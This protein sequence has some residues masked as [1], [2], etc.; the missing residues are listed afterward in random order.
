MTTTLTILGII[1]LVA[2][3]I[4]FALMAK[5]KIK[6]E[7]KNLIPDKL[8]D[9]YSTIDERIDQMKLEYQD[10]KEVVEELKKQVKDIEEAATGKKRRGRKPKNK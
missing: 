6:D 2:I 10:V 5:G 9:I 7:N 4:V 3:I 1:I 8:E